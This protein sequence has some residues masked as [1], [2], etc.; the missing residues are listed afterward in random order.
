M[1]L[2]TSLTLGRN[3][4]SHL[5]SFLPSLNG[6]ARFRQIPT[7]GRDSIRRFSNHVSE[8]KKLAARDYENL[9]Q[10]GVNCFRSTF[11]RLTVAI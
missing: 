7:F 6:P 8:L 10:V 11:P 5:P 9:L 1:G 4:L 3:C 2:L